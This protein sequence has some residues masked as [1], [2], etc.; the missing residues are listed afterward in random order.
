MA[1]TESTAT[2][3]AVDIVEAVAERDGVDETSLPPLYDTI[4]PDALD[5]VF[6]TPSSG[7]ADHH[8]RLSFQYCGHTIV[9]E[10]DRTITV[11]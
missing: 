5:V 6:D 8:P 9:I 10:P 7:A 4:D 11:E 2:P 3:L 1:T